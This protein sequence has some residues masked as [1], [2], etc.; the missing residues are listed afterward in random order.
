MELIRHGKTLVTGSAEGE[1]LSAEMGLSFWGG[2]DPQ[3]GV[4]IDQHHPLRDQSLAGR[5]LAIPSGRGSCSGSGVLLE[6]ILNGHAPAAIIICEREEILTLG[7]L[8]AEVMFAQS[9]PVLRVERE[10]FA[11]I[12]EYR[13]A[14]VVGS[15]LQLLHE[16]LDED[17][18]PGPAHQGSYEDT[19]ISLDAVDEAFLSGRHGKAA[20]VA[21]RLLLR[22]AAV[23]GAEAFMDVSQVHIDGC[24]YTGPASLRFAQMLLEWGARVRVPTTLN[25]ISVDKR[26]WR[27]Q[28]VAQDLGAPA[29][30]LADAYLAMGA[31]PSF[32]CAP[33]LLE[34][35]PRF[36]EQVGWAESNAVIYANSVIGARTMKYPDYLDVC[37][38]LTGR[39][40]L[41]GCHLD[42]G[43]RAT[44]A[45]EV[46]LPERADDA[47]WPLLGYCCGSVCGTEI[48]LICGLETS[49]AGLDELKA[50]GAAFAT[51]AAA[52]M[53]HIAGI[54]PEA[55]DQR[56]ERQVR[57][58]LGELRQALGALNTAASPEIGL[59][60]LGNPHFS[61]SECARLAA[62]VRGRTRSADVV[63]IVTCGRAVH[64]AARQAGHVA[65]AEAFGIQFITDTCWCM[66]S[67]PVIPPAVQTLMTNSGKYAHYAPGLVGRGVRF[68]S[69]AECVEA[70]CSGKAQEDLP[71][72][73]L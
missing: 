12:G 46:E 35:A 22:M 47:F 29:S 57:I 3:T 32:T 62:L 61:L 49:A 5:V 51:V 2:V 68:G 8:V 66:L 41:A 50:F 20:Q 17:W 40:P 45:L 33:Y 13:Y 25:S 39:A 1:L 4:V 65:E 24:I 21:M 73:L 43:R 64:E 14:R 56:P 9:I 11:R 18:Q 44:L 63:V 60:S 31:Q 36:G 58:G 42:A 30:A 23:Q 48:P 54:T 16:P 67:E 37:I 38:A 55:D 27:A 52:P 7:A 69:M 26:R 72:W 34:S 71:S 19:T 59:V 70:A 15:S 53:F 28:G 10:V 6:L